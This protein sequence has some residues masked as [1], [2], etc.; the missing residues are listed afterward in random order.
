MMCTF[1]V[2]DFWILCKLSFWQ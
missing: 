2:I 1:Y